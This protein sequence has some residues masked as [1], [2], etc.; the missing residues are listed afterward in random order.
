MTP[1]M[2]LNNI[3][4]D[5]PGDCVYRQSH[6]KLIMC[7]LGSDHMLVCDMSGNKISNWIKHKAKLPGNHGIYTHFEMELVFDQ[8]LVYFNYENDETQWK[9]WCMDLEHDEKWYPSHQELPFS[10]SQS[11]IADRNNNFHFS[12]FCK[13]DSIHFKASCFDLI[14]M[15]IIKMNIT[16][17]EPLITGF[18][19]KFEKKHEMI[20]LPMYLKKLIVK[21]YPIFV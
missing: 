15:E 1:F 18:I 8:I 7:Q 11:V 4:A 17:Y 14:P 5:H 13:N 16:K 3:I 12:S 10:V 9:I 20:F 19:K 2:G 21:F 6:Q